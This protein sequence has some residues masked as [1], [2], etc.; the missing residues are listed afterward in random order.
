[1]YSF[2]RQKMHP[3]HA[4]AGSMSEMKDSGDKYKSYKCT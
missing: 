1:M 3:D 2:V 4:K